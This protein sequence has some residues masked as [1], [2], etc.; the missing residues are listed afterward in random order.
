[1]VGLLFE[2]SVSLALLRRFM[3]GSLLPQNYDV[4]L[5]SE[6]VGDLRQRFNP[7]AYQL[8][9][10]FGMDGA[11]RLDRRL[12]IAAGVLLAAIEGKQRSE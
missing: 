12:G 3:L 2:D 11:R 10:D 1:M 9:M 5:G 7:F 6:R 8:D 4:T